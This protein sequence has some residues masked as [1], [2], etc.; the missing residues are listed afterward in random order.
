MQNDEPHRGG[1]MPRTEVTVLLP[2][3]G[4]V[5]CVRYTYIVKEAGD[6]LDG[7]AK[8]IRSTTHPVGSLFPQVPH[9]AHLC[10]DVSG[11]FQPQHGFS[12]L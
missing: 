2:G 4:P 3:L 11:C 12:M 8:Y 5:L 9:T 10:S 6:G 1:F 7:N